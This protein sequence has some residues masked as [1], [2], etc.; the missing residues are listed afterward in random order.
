[1][2]KELLER[3]TEALEGIREELEFM[4]EI[5]IKVNNDFTVEEN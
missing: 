2:D 4:N 3:I 1:M 5:G